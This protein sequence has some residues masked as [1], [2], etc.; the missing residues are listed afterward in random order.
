[1]CSLEKGFTILEKRKVILDVDP[2]IDDSLALLLA[3]LSNKFEVMGVTIGSGNV[4]IHQGAKNASKVLSLIH[5]EN[6]PIYKGTELPLTIKYTDARDTH[7]ED[8][9]GEAYFYQDDTSQSENAVDFIYETLRK[10]LK[11]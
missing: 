4:D 1:M 3:F 9:L 2:G 10:Y 8:G 11:K 5:Q 6:I 7:G